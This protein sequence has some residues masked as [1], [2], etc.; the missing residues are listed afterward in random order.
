MILNPLLPT[1]RTP[2]LSSDEYAKAQQA[3]ADFDEFL[4]ATDGKPKSIRKE[5]RSDNDSTGLSAKVIDP[6]TGKKRRVRGDKGKTFETQT[7]YLAE[8]SSGTY[9]TYIQ[10]G[11][12]TD[13][14][15]DGNT[16]LG[17][18][19]NVGYFAAGAGRYIT[20]PGSTPEDSIGHLLTGEIQLL[21][22]HS[23]SA[24]LQNETHEF[25]EHIFNSP[26]LPD[27]NVENGVA[28]KVSASRV[29]QK[30]LAKLNENTSLTAFNSLGASASTNFKSANATVQASIGLA[31]HHGNYKPWVQTGDNTSPT[32]SL[33]SKPYT[34]LTVDASIGRRFGD[35]FISVPEEGIED[36]KTFARAGITAH[37]AGPA[38]SQYFIGAHVE[39]GL[40]GNDKRVIQAS[41]GFSIPINHSN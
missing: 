31:I 2:A 41:A 6:S 15:V 37:Y 10:Q 35:S 40:T 33:N 8:Y 1:G 34:A 16:G 9:I 23:R 39:S 21:G 14:F 12:A 30:D 13:S 19:K 11:R 4:L 38:G 26:Q 17:I 29:R 36:R 18:S 7:T 5:T 20:K 27:D 25:I 22:D 32:I 24:D 3:V 28:V